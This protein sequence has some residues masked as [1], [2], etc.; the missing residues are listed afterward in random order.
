MWPGF[1]GNWLCKPE[2]LGRPGLEEM[3][4]SLLHQKSQKSMQ[5]VAKGH[6]HP[7]LLPTIYRLAPQSPASSDEC[8]CLYGSQ[9]SLGNLHGY[10]LPLLHFQL[11]DHNTE[12]RSAYSLLYVLTRWCF[13]FSASLWV[14][15]DNLTTY[16]MSNYL[17]KDYFLFLTKN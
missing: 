17:I 11:K 8:T 5:E 16:K 2:V 12:S 13:W 15:K 14:R 3:R 1:I 4:G 9:T 6:L 7:P 10:S